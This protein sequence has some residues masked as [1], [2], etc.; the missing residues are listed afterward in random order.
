MSN[1]EEEHPNNDPVNNVAQIIKNV[2]TSAADAEIGALYINSR[3]A[4]PVRQ[5]LM[6][7]G[8]GQPPTPIQ[9]DNTTALALKISIQKQLY[10]RE[11]TIGSCVIGKIG[12]SSVIT[13]KGQR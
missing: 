13:G 5:L 8:H 12:S 7:M 1:N 2:M 6:K 9:T 4:I 10:V 3:Q 11:R